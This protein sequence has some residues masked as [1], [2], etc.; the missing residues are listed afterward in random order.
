MLISA[1]LL[2]FY[3]FIYFKTWVL[4]LESLPKMGANWNFYLDISVN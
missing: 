4:N 1:C 3:L 2:N